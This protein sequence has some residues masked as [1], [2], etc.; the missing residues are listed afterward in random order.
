MGH[1]QGG[2]IAARLA[3]SGQYTTTGLITA[4][5]PLGST[6]V[7]GSYKALV[8]SHSDDV[9]PGLA[10][11]Y[12]PTRAW[13]IERHSGGD[14][15][16]LTGAHSLKSYAKTA[17]QVDSSPGADLWGDWSGEQGETTPTFYAAKR[18]LSG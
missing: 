9:V 1:S 6:P 14:T 3:E 12:E 16:D 18:K 15:G 4:G 11:H 5:A 8:L 13:R 10:G 2:I 17:Q 7:T